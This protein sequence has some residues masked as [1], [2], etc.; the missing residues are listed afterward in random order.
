[1]FDDQYVGIANLAPQLLDSLWRAASGAA[2]DG[3]TRHVNSG[4]RS[5]E[6]QQAL[7]SDAVAEHGSEA[8]AARWVASTD[9]SAHVRGHAVNVGPH[10][11]ASWLSQHGADYGLCE[12]YENEPWR[13][14]LRLDAVT[15][16]CPDLFPDPTADPRMRSELWKGRLPGR[17][18]CVRIGLGT[19]RFRRRCHRERWRRP[20]RPHRFQYLGRR[21]LQRGRACRVQSR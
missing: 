18:R 3:V 17:L 9:T 14:E 15:V 1:M 11:A 21:P 19:R 16:G 5:E 2:V 13:V 6:Y 20:R 4:W 7:F 12:L 10:E 8:A